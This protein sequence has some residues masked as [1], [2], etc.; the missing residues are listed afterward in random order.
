[1]GKPE[2]TLGK[3]ERTLLHVASFLP[4]LQTRSLAIPQRPA[5]RHGHGREDTGC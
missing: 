5:K 2:G 3:R 1:M 4:G